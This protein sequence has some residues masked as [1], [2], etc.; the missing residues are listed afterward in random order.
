MTFKEFQNGFIRNKQFEKYLYHG[1]CIA[2]IGFSLFMLCSL[3]TNSNSKITGNKTFYYFGFIFLL[4]LGIYGL[5]VLRGRYKL[6]YWHNDLSKEKNL[7]LFNSVCSELMKSSITLYD[8]QAYF[9]YRKSWWRMPYE[10]YLFADKNI[11]AINVEGLDLSNGGFLDF[12]ASRRTQN[13]ILSLFKE[14]AEI[15]N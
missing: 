15:F 12:G 7:E 1:L 5:F 4:L 8:N 6:S 10:V 2:I 9:V 11:I 13:K 3:A 14:K